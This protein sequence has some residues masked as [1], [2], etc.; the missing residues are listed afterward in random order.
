MGSENIASWIQTFIAHMSTTVH[1]V[2][3]H[4]PFPMCGILWLLY[5]CSLNAIIWI[6]KVVLSGS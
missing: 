4:A 6:L 3:A 1:F 2:R 5:N